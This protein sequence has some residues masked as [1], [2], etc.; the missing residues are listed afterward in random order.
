MKSPNRTRA[1][2]MRMAPLLV[3]VCLLTSYQ[4]TVGRIPATNDLGVFTFPGE[5]PNG[6]LSQT[7]GNDHPVD[8]EGEPSKNEVSVAAHPND[9]Q[10]V[11]AAMHD[12]A[13]N[14]GGQGPAVVAY[15]SIDG[16]ATYERTGVF[17]P[18]IPGTWTA[19][20]S[21]AFDSDG[22]A[23]VG[24][25]QGVVRESDGTYKGG[26]VYVVR[27]G[28]GGETWEKPRVAVPSVAQGVCAGPDKP[29]LGVGRG[30][31][32]RHD[33]VYLSWHEHQSTDP[34]SCRDF[35][36]GPIV[37]V[38]RSTNG[39][40]SFAPPVAITNL[41]E[42]AF[43]AMPR[44][45]PDGVLRVTFLLPGG[46]GCAT[47][48]D[49]SVRIVVATSPDG[50]QSFSRS[51]ISEPCVASDISNG[52]VGSANSIPILDISRSG[53]IAV[54]WAA[55][56][57]ETDN[58]LEVV[59][60]S[61][62]GRDW[63]QLPPIA[64]GPVAAALQEWVAFGP[65]ESLHVMYIA[66]APGGSYDAYVTSLKNGSWSDPTRLTSQSS[67][68]AGTYPGFGLGHYPGFDIGPDGRGHAMWTDARGAPAMYQQDV[69]TRS[70]RL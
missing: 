66:A 26:G 21:V 2:A 4:I 46:S 31:R 19:D 16:G 42:H 1:P 36:A 20:P 41:Q 37:K 23:Y 18:K 64:A 38:A 54:V 68:G 57:S 22:V 24:F 61:N 47:N 62:G 69:W 70:L 65:D 35:M 25:L 39:G 32:G 67:L 10:V 49:A 51:V 55:G 7:T 15:R 12:F 9:P 17:A 56:E 29:Y 40:R 34:E 14:P 53:K 63:H 27:S 60:S 44:V 3:V 30:Q 50:G 6:E 33:T 58:A 52:A 5:G 8:P 13:E 28:D 48:P 11:L 43:G 45:G 59:L